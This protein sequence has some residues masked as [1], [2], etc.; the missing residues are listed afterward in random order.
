[1]DTADHRGAR[2]EV[3]AAL[4]QLLQEIDALGVAFDEPVLRMLVIALLELA[5]LRVVIETDHLVTGLEQRGDEVARDKARGTR[6][7]NSH[8]LPFGRTLHTSNTGLPA[9]ICSDLYSLCGVA[10]NSTSDSSTTRSSETSDGSG[11]CGSVHRTCFA[12]SL[13]SF[14][15]LYASESRRSS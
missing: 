3:L 2:H 11:T 1:R 5:V 14:L 8:R 4:E 9:G 6:D 13:S 12:C 15:S 7:E 10:T